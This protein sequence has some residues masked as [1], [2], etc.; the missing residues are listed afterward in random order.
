[1]TCVADE[2]V[3]KLSKKSNISRLGDGICQHAVVETQHSLLKN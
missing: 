3:A 2:A 1:M